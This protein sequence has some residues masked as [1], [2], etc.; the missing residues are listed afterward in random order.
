ME[1]VT[2]EKPGGGQ[3]HSALGQ[4]TPYVSPKSLDATSPLVDYTDELSRQ[5]A[6]LCEIMAPLGYAL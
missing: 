2:V 5:R 3:S 6:R 1:D 4:W